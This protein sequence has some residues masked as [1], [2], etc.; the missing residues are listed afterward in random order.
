MRVNQKCIIPGDSRPLVWCF[1][2]WGFFFSPGLLSVLEAFTSAKTR[3][4]PGVLAPRFS[5]LL[6][7]V[8]AE[9]AMDAVGV[10]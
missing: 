5:P 10:N 8:C 2:F 7:E 9:I 1:A 6:A 4:D 3:L